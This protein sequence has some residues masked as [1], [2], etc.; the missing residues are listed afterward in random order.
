M[1]R[2][3]LRGTWNARIR[4]HATQHR[5]YLERDGHDAATATWWRVARR[6]LPAWAKDAE[7]FWLMAD[8]YERKNGVIARTYEIALPRELSDQG[9]LDLA[10]DIRA[11]LFAQYPHTWAVHC[12]EVAPRSH[13]Q[14]TSGREG[15]TPLHVMF[16][17]TAGGC[18]V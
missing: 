6:S 5:R 2:W 8:R 10:D 1:G 15:A 14:E 13:G 7:H 18:A 12:P 4:T 17:T 9:R 16:S 11:A 3:G